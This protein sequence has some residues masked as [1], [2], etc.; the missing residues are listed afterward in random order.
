MPCISYETPG[1]I[2]ASLTA[3]HRRQEQEFEHNSTLAETFCKTMQ[4]IEEL[5]GRLYGHNLNFKLMDRLPFAARTWWGAHR[6]RDRDRLIKDFKKLKTKGQRSA[7]FKKLTVYEQKLIDTWLE[8]VNDVAAERAAEQERLGRLK[9]SGL[10]KL[11][12]PER[13]ALGLD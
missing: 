8:E 10:S 2:A 9:Q 7:A 13:K 6:N 5:D 11:T 4:E 3:D 1:E 12:P